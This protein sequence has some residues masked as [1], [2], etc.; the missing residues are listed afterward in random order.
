MEMK[1]HILPY[2]SVGELLQKEK[3]FTD[4][5]EPAVYKGTISKYETTIYIGPTS[6]YLEIIIWV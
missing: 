2:D 5:L 1:V 3:F 4:V 6:F